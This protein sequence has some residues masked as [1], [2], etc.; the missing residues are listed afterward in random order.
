MPDEDPADA[1]FTIGVEEEYQ[2]VDPGTRQLAPRVEQVLPAAEARVVPEEVSHELHET[3][4][5]IGTPVC[6][7]LAEVRAELVRLRTELAVAAASRG[8]RI[9]AAG[10]HPTAPVD[11]GHITAEPDYRAIAGR[12][13]QLAT[14]Q[15][16]FGCHVHVGVADR[17]LAIA[18][19]NS[20]RPW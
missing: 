15:K 11:E 1:D 6:R 16:V 5:E 12:Y 8:L 14:E 9:A 7:T 20:L 10:S 13:A 2:L 3:M 19:M 18:A 4:I 17:E